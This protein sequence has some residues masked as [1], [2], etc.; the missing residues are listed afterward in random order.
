MANSLEIRL[1]GPFEVVAGGRP[2]A[3]TGT[4]R[5]GLLALLALHRGRVLGVDEL[6]DALWGA[7]L[8]ASP[9]NALQHHVA[10]L[11]A[12]LGQESIVGSSDGYA[13]SDAS[14]DAVRFE[15]LLGE[16]RGALRAGD[17]RVGSESTELA[18][19][20]WRGR[21]LQGLGETDWFRAEARR[22]EG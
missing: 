3:V 14:V 4:K 18:L 8:P 5:H 11:R 13:L 21:A 16:A 22:L 20:L 12:V 10:R 1:L 7:D 6:I 17:A 9:R 15:E 2:A 19:G